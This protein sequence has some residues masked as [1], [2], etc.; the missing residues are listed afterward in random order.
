MKRSVVFKFVLMVVASGV[1]SCVAWAQTIKTFTSLQAWQAAVQ[2]SSQFSQTFQE[3]T[4]DTYFQTAAL[5]V[6]PFSLQQIG[7][8]PTFGLFQNFIDVPPLQFTD[9]SG[10]TN[11]AL[12]TKFGVVTVAMNFSLPVFGWGANFYDAETGELENL[13]LTGTGGTVIATV[14]VTVNTGFFGFVISPSEGI[15]GITFESRLD[16]PDPTVGQGFGLENVVGALTGTAALVL[17]PGSVNFGNVKVFTVSPTVSITVTNYTNQTAV[18]ESSSGLGEFSFDPGTCVSID[19][20]ALAPGAS[21]SFGVSFR[22]TTVGPAKGSITFKTFDGPVTFRLSG[23]GD[24][25]E[26][27]ARQ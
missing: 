19:P 15:A 11:A 27:S 20:F 2:G 3:F 1:L 8:D 6:G 14:P 13:V 24:K 9:N 7:R 4:E 18:Y 22:P 23:F 10:V 12:Y 26:S 17:N 5:R 16:I 25:Y 21:C